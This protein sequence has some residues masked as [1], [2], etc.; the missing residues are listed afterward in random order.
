MEAQATDSV[1]S[2]STDCS[3]AWKTFGSDTEAGRLLKKLY[4]GNVK[5]KIVYPK[6]KTKPRDAIEP[7][8]PAGGQLGT[9]SRTH[10][11]A[12]RVSDRAIKAPSFPMHR[13]GRPELYPIDYM[14]GRRKPYSE[15]ERE[16]NEIKRQMEAYRSSCVRKK[17]NQ[18]K[19]KLQQVF[20]YTAGTILPRELLPGSDLLDR[21]LSHANALRIGKNPKSKLEQLEEIYDAVLN[22]V[23]SRKTYASEMIALGRPEKAEAVEKEILERFSELRRIHELMIRERSNNSGV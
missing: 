15:I 7:F 14:A 21:E 16:I 1:R 17:P 13:A 23:E 19:E 4:C 12:A 6:P 8:I 10:H 18:E 5:P 11:H 9:E 20:S 22:E 3:D 2:A